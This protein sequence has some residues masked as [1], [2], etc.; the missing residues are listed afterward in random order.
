[1]CYIYTYYTMVST[2]NAKKYVI[3]PETRMNTAKERNGTISDA[4]P[5][6]RS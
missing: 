3:L 1:M 5:F 4:V 6:Y 2:Y